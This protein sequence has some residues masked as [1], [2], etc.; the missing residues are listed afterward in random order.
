MR[1]LFVILLILPLSTVTVSAQGICEEYDLNDN[2]VFD[3]N[4]FKK[5]IW[6]YKNG[7]IDD[8]QFKEIIRCASDS[9]KR[10]QLLSSHTQSEGDDWTRCGDLNNDGNWTWADAW[11]MLDY[12]DGPGP[13]PADLDC[14]GTVTSNDFLLF[15]CDCHGGDECPH[16]CPPESVPALTLTGLTLLAG[17]LIVVGV[18]IIKGGKI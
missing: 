5:A 8:E 10:A 7:T 1:W 12:V 6:D 18:A 14:D 16:C 11:I 2:D 17:S 3:S 13:W 4:E 9:K 15:V